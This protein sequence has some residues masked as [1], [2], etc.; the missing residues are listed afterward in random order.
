[1]VMAAMP[2]DDEPPRTSSDWPGSSSSASS[3][4]HAVPKLSG[5]A[6]SCGQESDVSTG[7]TCVTGSSAYS[8]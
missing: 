2:T 8:A 3:E 6:P 4:P 7:I 1:M 5:I